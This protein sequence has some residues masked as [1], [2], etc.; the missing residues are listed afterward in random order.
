[1]SFTVFT[2]IV[3]INSGHFFRAPLAVPEPCFMAGKVTLAGGYSLT[4]CHVSSTIPCPL[5]VVYHIILITLY[6]WGN[7]GTESFLFG[8]SSFLGDRVTKLGF[9]PRYLGSR[10]YS[11]SH[12]A[13]PPSVSLKVDLSKSVCNWGKLLHIKDSVAFL[14]IQIMNVLQD[15]TF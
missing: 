10:A 14:A 13:I 15:P 1:M 7:W 4:T 11:F 12:Y 5:C 2:T 3:F 6:K 8:F 9:N